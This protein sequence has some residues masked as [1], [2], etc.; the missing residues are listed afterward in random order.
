[1]IKEAEGRR[2][3]GRVRF[4]KLLCVQSRADGART[5]MD[6]KHQRPLHV[7]KLE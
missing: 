1:M 5:D 6:R 3:D 2:A 4:A 7:E